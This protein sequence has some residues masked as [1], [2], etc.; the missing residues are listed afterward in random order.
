MGTGRIKHITR[1]ILIAL[2]VLSIVS[3]LAACDTKSALYISHGDSI[4]W[5]DSNKYPDGSLCV[6][7]QSYIINALGIKQYTN[8][9]V[10]GAPIANGT[11]NG[12]GVVNTILSVNHANYEICTIAVGTNDF[13]LDVPLGTISANNYDDTTF[14]GAYQQSIE[15]ILRQNN[16]I[17]LVLITPIHRDKDGYTSSS[18]NLAG[19]YLSDY[20]NAVI[21]L[22]KLYGIPAI[23]CYNNFEINSK[24]IFQYTIDGLHPNNNGHKIIGEYVSQYIIRKP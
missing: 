14:I 2:I 13:R 18:Q 9:G 17:R 22:G 8:K 15:H 7:Y 3:I 1:T 4:T 20:V 19:Y 5:Y 23:D 6:G 24:N 10:S 21:E 16:N 12:D 11:R